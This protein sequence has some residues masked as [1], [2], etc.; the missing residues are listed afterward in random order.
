MNLCPPYAEGWATFLHPASRQPVNQ[1]VV[2]PANGNDHDQQPVIDDLVHQTVAD[3]AK[4]DLITIRQAGK[5]GR[6]NMR[7][8]EPFGQ[9]LFKLFPDTAVVL[10]PLHEG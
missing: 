2:A 5:F 10:A 4:L 8:F 9:T 1:I 7:R 3:V 6:K